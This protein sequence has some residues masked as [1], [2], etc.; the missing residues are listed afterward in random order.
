[1]LRRR[2]TL[3]GVSLQSR[4]RQGAGGGHFF[5]G[6]SGS[7]YRRSLIASFRL[8]FLLL[9]ASVLVYSQTPATRPVLPGSPLPGISAHEFELFRMGLEDFTEVETPEDG[10]GPAFNGTSCAVCHATPAIGGI[11]TVTEVRAGYR[12]ENGVFTALHGGTLYHLFSV[13]GHRCQ[14]QIPP[15]ANVVARRAPIP[16]FG[17]GLVEA[18]PDDAIVSLEDPEDRDGDGISGRAGRVTDLATGRE[19]V[20]RFGWKSQHATLLA[21]AADAYRNE[22]GIT[23]ELFPDEVALGVDP[24]QLKLCAPPRKGLEDVRDRRTQMRGIDNFESFMRFLAPIERGP[25]DDSVRAGEALF[26]SIGC[27]RCHTPVLTTG[28]N[29]NALF[30]RKPVALFSDLLLHDVGTGDGIEQAPAAANEI[31]TPA[32]WGLRFRRPL[33][34][35]GSA[36]TIEEAITRH[37]GEA[38][39]VTARF[40]QLSAVDRDILLAFLR[41]L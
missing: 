29:A 2:T 11:S 20:G 18:I 37:G 16:V 38:A 7:G 41:S 9:A 5:T 14:V 23:N 25:V 34:H 8:S 35:D 4:D 13:P 3:H 39:A 28:P 22:M 10:L 6:P 17:A 26:A 15:E 31:R 24:E 12:D 19:R 36:S 33:L 21:F 32:L 40:A 27:A 30:D 1:M